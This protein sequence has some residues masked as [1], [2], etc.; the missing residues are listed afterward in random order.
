MNW[1]TE[2][3]KQGHGRPLKTFKEDLEAT[4]ELTWRVHMMTTH[5]GENL[6]PNVPA[7]MGATRSKCKV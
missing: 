3:G 6:L 1:V 7:G 5:D 4:N 2:G